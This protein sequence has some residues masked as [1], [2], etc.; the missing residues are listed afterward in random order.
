MLNV[1]PDIKLAV[2]FFLCPFR[3]Q[4]FYN[5]NIYQYVFLSFPWKDSTY[6]RC[7]SNKFEEFN[8]RAPLR[9][10]VL[11]VLSSMVHCLYISISSTC[12]QCA[13]SNW[14]QHMTNMGGSNTL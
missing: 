7:T 9:G 11:W 3:W 10:Q 2:T 13:N 6:V 4:L 5:L 12:E 8:A 1:Q 14:P